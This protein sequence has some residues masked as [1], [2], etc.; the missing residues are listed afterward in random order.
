MT[1]VAIWYEPSDNA[2]WCAADTRISVPGR[3]GGVTVR[4][5]SGTKIFSL[6]VQCTVIPS[7][8]PI[9]LPQQRVP[10]FRQTYGFAF[11]GDLQ[12]AM[13]TAAT[14]STLL[15]Q[16]EAVDA[17][18]PPS[19]NDVAIFVQKLA[20]RFSN[21]ALT[22]SG[23]SYGKFE[24]SVFGYCPVS[25][26]HEAYHLKPVSNGCSFDVCMQC[27]ST[28]ELTL[29]PLAFGS[30]SASFQSELEKLQTS[31]DLHSR[32]RR[33]PKIAV[34]ILTEHGPVVD[35]G[36]DLSLGISSVHGFTIYRNVAPIE[37]GKP[38]ARVT[39]N[40]IDIEN[41]IGMVGACMV[42]MPGMA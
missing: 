31:G 19:L 29:R 25:M 13:T 16:L 1:I 30:G 18:R 34:Q 32:T 37:Y 9:Q 20:K 7:A 23:H 21:E 39:Y 12:S 24:A 28:E 2:I 4:T 8:P 15:Q 33:L 6:P 10:F 42:G 11:A 17:R 38:Q 26:R 27:H 22:N 36:G 35:V 3:T 40:G 14:A 41:E 5:D